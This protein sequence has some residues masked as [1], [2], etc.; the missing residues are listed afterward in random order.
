MATCVLQRLALLHG[1]NV[2]GDIQRDREIGQ[3]LNELV[4]HDAGQ[5]AHIQDLSVIAIKLIVI[6]GPKVKITGRYKRFCSQPGPD[7]III[8]ECEAVVRAEHIMDKLQALCAG[9]RIDLTAECLILRCH[10]P[11]NAGK[12]P[13]CFLK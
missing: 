12:V 10:I 11:F 8:F 13:L 1:I 2:D 6:I 4:A 7:Q 5:T 3:L 9:Q